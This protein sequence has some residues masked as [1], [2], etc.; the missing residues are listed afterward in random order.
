MTEAT[1][2][3]WEKKLAALSSVV[4]GVVQVSLKVFLALATGSLGVLSEALHS[5]LDL[6]AAVLTYLS[7]RVADRPADVE[8]P[9]GH[10]KVENFAAL[11]EAGLLMLTAIY[12]I[13]EAFHRLL[14]HRVHLRPSL[15]AVGVLG[16]AM[17]IDWWRGRALVAV[18]RRYQS[19]ALEADALH[20]STDV[21]ST[22]VVLL[23]MLTVW[24]GERL[25]APWLAYADPIAAL[26]VSAVILQVGARL[27]R[28][29]L[30]A[31]LDR[32]PEELRERI[33]QV[34]EAAE[35]VLDVYRL[36]V[37][38]A[39]SRYF[40]DVTIAASRSLTL[41]Q[42]HDLSD[43]VEQAVQLI[44]PADVMVHVEP[45]PAL[46]EHLFD[47]IRGAARRS[48]LA[49][50][51]ISAQQLDGRL[52]VDLHLEVD[53]RLSLREAHRRASELEERIREHT[54]PESEINIHIEPLGMQIRDA[55]SVDELTRA[56]EAHLES[57]RSR[58]PELTDCHQVRVRTVEHRILVSCHCSMDGDLPVTRAH[59]ITAELEQSLRR[60]FPEIDRITI[61]PE[62]AGES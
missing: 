37:R 61:H 17:A 23:G 2:G 46:G 27:S 51:E 26:G 6:M 53:E 59:D 40:V 4:A 29:T 33:R 15:M 35:G 16:V 30:D 45:R 1:A 55:R 34:V 32:A 62:P 20:F 3:T 28:R 60:A 57:I 41:E 21:W 12:V 8:H 24:A 49:V 18:A 13:F 10:G 22:L 43:A 7:V 48:G 42:A 14:F 56:I 38:R 47:A 31:L 39:G 52:F 25:R 44:V 5:G 9:Y 54:G 58:F 36:R 19:D 50:H 11:I